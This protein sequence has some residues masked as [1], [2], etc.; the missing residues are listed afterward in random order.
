M[1]WV[2]Q[3]LRG[4]LEKIISFQYWNFSYVYIWET[5]FAPM[6]TLKITAND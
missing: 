2:I 4:G 5:K 6:I 1:T 3:F